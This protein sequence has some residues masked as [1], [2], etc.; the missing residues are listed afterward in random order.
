MRKVLFVIGFVL[1][2]GT[3]QV[4][5]QKLGTEPGFVEALAFS[6]TGKHLVYVSSE[7]PDQKCDEQD[8]AVLDPEIFAGTSAFTNLQLAMIFGQEVQIA[9][10]GCI[11]AND[12]EGPVEKT[13]IQKKIPRIVDI[14][15]YGKIGLK[16]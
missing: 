14:I 3:G 9:V 16:P 10:E 7:I 6:N 8:F 2:A 5:A 12:L 4:Q 11:D 1:C 13:K 15:F